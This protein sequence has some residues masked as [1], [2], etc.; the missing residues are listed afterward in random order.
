MPGYI[1][2]GFVICGLYA[3]ITFNPIMPCGIPSSSHTALHNEQQLFAG[4]SYL[5]AGTAGTI[6][7]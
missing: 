5:T 1:M 7:M 6:N 3:K 4:L 2:L